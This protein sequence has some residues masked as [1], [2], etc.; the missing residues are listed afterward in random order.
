MD[1]YEGRDGTKVV[2]GE[3]RG[4]RRSETPRQ[5]ENHTCSYQTNLIAPGLFSLKKKKNYTG[6][7]TGFKFYFNIKVWW[8]IVFFSINEREN[9]FHSS[10]KNTSLVK[11]KEKLLKKYLEAKWIQASLYRLGQWFSF[12]INTEE[13]RHLPRSRVK[14]AK[15]RNFILNCVPASTYSLGQIRTFLFFRIFK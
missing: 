3:A 4:Q 14:G 6:N 5:I 2:V 9:W 10:G 8:W 12:L 7:E 15:S 1:R 13:P 11:E